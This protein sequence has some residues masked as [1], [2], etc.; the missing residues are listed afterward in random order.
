MVDS[1]PWVT[2]ERTEIRFNLVRPRFGH[3]RI[4]VGIIK[5]FVHE[6]K[7]HRSYGIFIYLFVFFQSATTRLPCETS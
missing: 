3:L 2:D 1:T 6:K 4:V 5:A 7:P